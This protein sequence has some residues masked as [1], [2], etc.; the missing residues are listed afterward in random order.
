[1]DEDDKDVLVHFDGWSSRYDEYIEIDGG[2]LRVLSQEALQL[3][4][5]KRVK[6]K[7]CVCV[8]ARACVCVCV[9]ACVCVRVCVC[10]CNL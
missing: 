8:C 3:A 6:R 1:M 9:C 2:R 5:Q 7:V 10:V 4:E